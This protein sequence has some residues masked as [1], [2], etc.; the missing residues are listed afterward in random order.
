MPLAKANFDVPPDS[1]ESVLAET[2]SAE[3]GPSETGSAEI[4]ETA[5]E[6]ATEPP[7]SGL[8]AAIATLLNLEIA[9]AAFDPDPGLIQQG[10]AI[11]DETLSATTMTLP[12]FW[13]RR[14][15]VTDRLNNLRAV[16]A[17]VVYNGDSTHPRRADFA[18][19]PQFW[20]RLS[21]IER[22]MLLNQL[23]SAG[24][25]YGYSVRL[26]RGQ[27]PVAAHICDFGP[28]PDFAFGPKADYDYRTVEDLSCV[29]LM[30]YVGRRSL[31]NQHVIDSNGNGNGNGRR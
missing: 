15:Q 21:Y 3:T 13:W 18:V 10:Q 30:D 20:N 27:D 8:E 22:Y 14:T 16:Q 24:V 12:S 2:D 4:L 7:R 9:P 1:A 19:D 26:F 11:T 17:W 25:G 23:G 5:P 6:P 31:R 28:H 29:V